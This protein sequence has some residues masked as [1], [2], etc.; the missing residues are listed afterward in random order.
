MQSITIPQINERLKGLSSDKLAVV[1]DFISYLA[2]KE[3]SDVL[4]NS[5]TKAIECTYASE[6][7]L[8]RDWNRPEE[9]EAWA[10]L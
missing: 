8:A 6:Q 10:T 5:A 3:L 7:V 2:E 4:L 1:F 9:D